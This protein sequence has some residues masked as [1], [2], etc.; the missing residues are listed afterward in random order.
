MGTLDGKAALVTGG[1]RG[2]GRAI[3]HRLAAEGATVAFT[4]AEN[5]RAAN[6]VVTEIEEKGGA[7]T[8]VQADQ[9]DLAGL[10]EL[11]ATA[12]ESTGGLDILVIN[13]AINLV[14]P[15]GDTTEADYDR[16][17][18]VNAKG[19]FFAIQ[20]AGRVLRDGGRIISFSTLNTVIPVP[21]N[22]LYI[23]GKAAIEQF[24][25]VAARE[26]GPRGITVNCVSPGATDT[27]LLR[28]SNPNETFE[29]VKAMTALGRLG[30]PADVADVV[31]FLAGPDSRWITGQNLRVTGGLLI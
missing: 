10:P 5:E 19:P 14:K 28:D 23:A 31:A 22:A 17:M 18:A 9:A 29:T 2:I 20:Q 30:E 16:M 26:F 3:V 25:A 11:F 27:D 13:A 1:S 4:Y 12:A 7:A 21:G 6:G 8:A 15:I 24:T